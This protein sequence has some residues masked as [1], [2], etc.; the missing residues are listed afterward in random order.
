MQIIILP[1]LAIIAMAIFEYDDGVLVVL[2]RSDKYVI[3]LVNGYI[4]VKAS[5]IFFINGFDIVEF[6]ELTT[7]HMILVRH[8]VAPPAFND[9][10]VVE[11]HLSYP[12]EK[13]CSPIWRPKRLTGIPRTAI[14]RIRKFSNVIEVCSLIY[15]TISSIL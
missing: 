5:A 14:I 10:A 3:I 8:I 2:L 15:F 9:L 1:Y 6:V 12:M 7:A 4:S 11:V 13:L